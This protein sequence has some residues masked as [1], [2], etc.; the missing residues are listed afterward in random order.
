MPGGMWDLSSPTRDQTRAPA[1][2]ALHSLPWK[3]CA[4]C[5]GRPMPP[6]LEGL[7]PC[8]GRPVPPALEA[9]HSLPWKA[10]APCTGRPAPPALEGL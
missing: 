9:L 8:P 4:P 3:A 6:A 5:T 7:R 1:L 10:C 2:E